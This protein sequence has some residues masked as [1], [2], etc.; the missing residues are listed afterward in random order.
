MSMLEHLLTFKL[1]SMTLQKRIMDCIRAVCNLSLS[2]SG[3]IKS[4]RHLK[5]SMLNEIAGI[6]LLLFLINFE[7]NF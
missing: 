6:Y 2:M 1:M 7:V 4:C 3:G 5:W